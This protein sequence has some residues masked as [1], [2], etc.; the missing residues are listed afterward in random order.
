MYVSARSH[1][2]GE[3]VNRATTLASTL[4]HLGGMNAKTRPRST[5]EIP[6][7]NPAVPTAR[8]RPDVEEC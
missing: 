5:D 1:T 2:V 7:R 6:P 4:H 3:R 8:K